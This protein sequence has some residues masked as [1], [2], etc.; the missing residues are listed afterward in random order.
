MMVQLQTSP[1]PGLRLRPYIPVHRGRIHAD[2]SSNQTKNSTR[3]LLG[4]VIVNIKL[5]LEYIE[6]TLFGCSKVL[7]KIIEAMKSQDG[8]LQAKHVI[9]MDGGATTRLEFSL[10][11]EQR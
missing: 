5:E 7:A 3:S 11:P 6:N 9:S 10:I 2:W 8:A 4:D 1:L